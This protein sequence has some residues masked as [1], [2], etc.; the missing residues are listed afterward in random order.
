MEILLELMDVLTRRIIYDVFV[1]VSLEMHCRF[2]CLME[3]CGDQS[4]NKMTL[5]ICK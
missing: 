5:E 4:Y 3:Q 2:N 1:D